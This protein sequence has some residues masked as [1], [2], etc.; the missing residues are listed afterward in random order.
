M[1]LQFYLACFVINL[2]Q[3]TSHS[4]YKNNVYEL[5]TI[6]VFFIECKLKK[7]HWFNHLQQLQ[8]IPTWKRFSKILDTHNSILKYSYSICINIVWIKRNTCHFKTN[9]CTYLSNSRI[10]AIQNAW[11]CDQCSFKV[12]YNSINFTTIVWRWNNIWFNYQKK[13]WI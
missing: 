5:F 12:K 4:S 1:T 10:W 13:T 6:Y 3:E 2:V 7:Y 8:K 9:I 11:E